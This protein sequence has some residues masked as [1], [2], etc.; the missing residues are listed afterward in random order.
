[1]PGNTGFR[2]HEELG[3]QTL[4]GVDT[5]GT[6]D[7]TTI[8]AGVY[9]NDRPFLIT[10]EFWFA[11]SLGINLLSEI[12]DPSFGKEIFTVTDVSLAEPDPSLYEL[13]EGFEVADHRKT[14]PP[15]E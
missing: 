10:R 7:T 5:V 12:T 3:T 1:M 15:Q 4:A 11:A 14:A 2:T 9:G 6:K 13:P 8:N